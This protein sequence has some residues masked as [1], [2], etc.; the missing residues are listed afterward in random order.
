MSLPL[1]YA[2]FHNVDDDQRL[3]LTC[4]GTRADLARLGIELREALRLTFYMDDAND[5]GERDDL[6]ADGEVHYDVAAGYWIA[7][8]DWQTLRHASEDRR[9]PK[10]PDRAGSPAGAGCSAQGSVAE[11]ARRDVPSG[12]GIAK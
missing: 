1:V 5:A 12:E 2:D 6:L 10:S 4:A 7:A 11:A 8:L 9:Q 3:R